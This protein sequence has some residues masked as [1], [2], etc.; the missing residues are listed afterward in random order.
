VGTSLEMVPHEMQTVTEY[1][2]VLCLRSW[3]G[4]QMVKLQIYCSV[5]CSKTDYGSIMHNFTAVAA[6]CS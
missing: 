3:F 4:N 5:I 6:V 2:K 1:V